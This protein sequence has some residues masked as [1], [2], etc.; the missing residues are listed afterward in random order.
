[1]GALFLIPIL[2]VVVAVVAAF[3]AYKH[4]P[5]INVDGAKVEAAIDAAKAD[6]AAVK[7]D[8]VKAEAKL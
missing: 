8:V 4:A 3:L 6:V 7:A 2:F 5:E 1:M